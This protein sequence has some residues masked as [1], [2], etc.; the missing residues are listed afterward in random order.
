MA[1][2][3]AA[4]A[5]ACIAWSQALPQLA[6]H[7]SERCWWQLANR[8]VAIA[9]DQRRADDLLAMHMLHAE[10]PVVL[11]YV[12]PELAECRS[13]VATARRT[14]E[15]SSVEPLEE[16]E[17]VHGLRL[18]LLRPLLACWTRTRAIGQTLDDAPWSD[19][20]LRQYARLVEY[21]L[22]L[23]RSDGRQ[24]FQADGSPSWNRRLLKTALRLADHAKTRRVGQ[25][26]K[27]HGK[28]TTTGRQRT[29]RPSFQHE[30][31]GIA[32][33]RSSWRLSSP[34][35]TINHAAPQLATELALGKA[36]LWTGPHEVEVQ[37]DG[38]LLAPRHAWEQI[39][40]ESDDDV[41]YLELELKLSDDVIIQRHMALARGDRFLLLADAVLGERPAKIEYR[42][43]LPL[44]SRAVFRGEQET[45]EGT[46]VTTAGLAARVLPLAL[47]EWRS[48]PSCGSL[49]AVGHALELTQT[50]DGA[51]LFAPLF[52]DL[53][54]R[55]M[56]KEVTWR[57][58]TVGESRSA[59]GSDE[60]VG[61]RVQIGRAQWLIYRS[62]A[63][64]AVRTVLGKNLL[65]E[66]LIGRF[67]THGS[68]ETLL[69]I[70]A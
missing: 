12:L 38:R 21:A 9:S 8:L 63:E 24:V 28:G 31:G 54:P 59:V 70:E 22:R 35:W 18:D 53:D 3:D 10:L 34:Q 61:Y 45:R 25:L 23:S 64:P 37:L 36:C 33:L 20:A 32:V 41:D 51:R 15:R 4:F 26:L 6:E 44:G 58:L 17:P 39:C 2:A 55:R 27:T 48:G 66:L 19:D 69:E 47:G 60:A 16:N 43:T 40:W 49:H 50:A 52:V 67:D 62:L 11:A 14:L 56:A 29:P 13:L 1:P 65:N 5:L 68:V 30:S 42:S 7:L 46:I 57:Q